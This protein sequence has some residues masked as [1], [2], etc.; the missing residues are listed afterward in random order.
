MT[1]HEWMI[2]KSVKSTAEFISSPKID[3]NVFIVNPT[4][5]S[6]TLSTLKLLSAEL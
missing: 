1:S 4:K 6:Q 2:T 5:L 3:E